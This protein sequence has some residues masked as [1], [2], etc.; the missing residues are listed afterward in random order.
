MQQLVSKGQ[1]STIQVMV[2][3]LIV[4]ILVLFL[5]IT[6][7]SSTAETL[8]DVGRTSESFSSRL[9]LLNLKSLTVASERSDNPTVGTPISYACEY[10]Y[11]GTL[12]PVGQQQYIS[13]SFEAEEE[14]DTLAYVE[15][16]L[17]TAIDGNYHLRIDCGIENGDRKVFQV[18]DPPPDETD[19]LVA[20]LNVPKAE[21]GVVEVL[22]H[23]WS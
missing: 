5:F 21:N 18:N 22:L 3:S 16:Y 4:A 23:R 6:Q 1:G 7:T 15:N 12:R 10:S 2:G 13:E 20:Q 19:T 17:E 8:Q 14:F 9:V 11:D